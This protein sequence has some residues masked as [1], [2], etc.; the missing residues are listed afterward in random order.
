MEPVVHC[1]ESRVIS[2]EKQSEVQLKVKARHLRFHHSPED[3]DVFC[4][5]FADLG[6]DVDVGNSTPVGSL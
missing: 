3:T 4:K 5:Q 6:V 1:P 2:L